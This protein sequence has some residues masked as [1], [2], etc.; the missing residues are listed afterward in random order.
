MT[1]LIHLGLATI[2]F[3][4]QNWIGAKAYS[5]GYIKFSLLDELKQFIGSQNEFIKKTILL[6]QIEKSENIT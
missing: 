5:K 4:I 6:A 2:L 1:T 3:L